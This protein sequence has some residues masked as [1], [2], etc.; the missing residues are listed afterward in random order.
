M[1]RFA[2]AAGLADNEAGRSLCS[3][4]CKTE[5]CSAQD[6]SDAML[7]IQRALAYGDRV[8]QESSARLAEEE[9]SPAS[10]VQT[11]LSLCQAR[12][13]MHVMR[14]LIKLEPKSGP[15][16]CMGQGLRGCDCFRMQVGHCSALVSLQDAMRT[17]HAAYCQ[18]QGFAKQG[19]CLSCG[20]LT[21][22]F[23]E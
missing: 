20:S 5:T 15:D 2:P 7:C 23:L 10:H 11:C 4:H 13:V 12:P 3:G 6:A 22:N 8:L 14:L 9:V 16:T 19:V 18:K 17:V 21:L 1:H